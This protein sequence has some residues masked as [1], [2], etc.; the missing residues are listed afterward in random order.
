MDRYIAK[1]S[2]LLLWLDNTYKTKEKNQN[3][4]KR[5]GAGVE[6]KGKC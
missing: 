5:V 3:E 1:R 2:K 6:K 4:K